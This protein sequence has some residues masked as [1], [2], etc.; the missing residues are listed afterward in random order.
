MRVIGRAVIVHVPMCASQVL[1]E[2]VSTKG[3]YVM[4]VPMNKNICDMNKYKYVRNVDN[5][6]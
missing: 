6:L 5:Q 2:V 3:T 1:L 4:L